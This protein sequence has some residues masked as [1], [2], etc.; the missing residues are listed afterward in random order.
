MKNTTPRVDNPNKPLSSRPPQKTVSG[1]AMEQ[2][3][4][5]K[6]VNQLLRSSQLWGE[7]AKGSKFSFL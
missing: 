7:T 1:R 6:A 2:L 5:Y 4:F 3:S